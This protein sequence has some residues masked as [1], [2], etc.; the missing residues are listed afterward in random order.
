MDQT[1]SQLMIVDDK[2]NGNNI[3]IFFFVRRIQKEFYLLGYN[4]V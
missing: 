2:G 1:L 4:T 3:C